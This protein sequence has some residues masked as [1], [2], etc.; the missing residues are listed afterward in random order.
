[1]SNK[2]KIYGDIESGSIFFVGST[3]D[4]KPLGGVV[5][6][7]EHPTIADRI[8][9]KRNDR[10]KRDRISFRVL[11]RKLN[12]NRICNKQGEELVEQLGYDRAQVIEYINGQANLQDGASAGGDGN[13]T[14]LIG[15][16]VCFKLDDTSTSVMIDTGHEFGVNTIKAIE[17]S[18]N[19][20]I[21]SELG[22]LVHFTNLEVGRVCGDDGNVV[23]GGLNDVI[24]Y[25]NELFTVGAFTQVVITDPDAT[26]VADVGGVDA[27][28]YVT[29]ANA[30]DPIG[31]DVYVN[32]GY[33]SLAGL[34]TTETISKQGEYFTFDIR[35]EGQ[36][37]FGLVHTQA[38]FDAGKW[39]GSS[40][41]GDPSKFATQN[42][43]HFGF[44]FSHWFHQ[45]PNGSWTNY[46]ANTSYITGPAWSGGWD[47]QQDWLDGE[48][49]KIK[50]GIDN[51][52]YIGIY[53]LNN[54]GITWKLHARTAYALPEGGE[55]RLGIKSANST[56]RVSSAPKVHLLPVTA[57]TMYFRYIESPDGVFQYPL[58][59]STEEAEY[60]DTEAGGSGTYHSHVYADDP[61]NTTWYMPDT[62]AVHNGTFAPV[63]DLTL[64]QPANYTEI[65][66]LSNSDLAPAAYADTS[67]TIDEG[68]TINIQ[69]Q[70][71]DTGYTTTFA[72]LPLGLIGF[73]GNVN[74]TAPQVVGDNVANPSDT[75]TI[76]VIR[77]N[78]YGSSTGTLTLVVNNLTAPV[79]TPITGVTDE[80]GTSL[81]DS[82]T[83]DDGSAVSID[84]VVNVGN[85]FT[86][87]KEWIDNYV[88]PK[89][90]SGTGAKAIYIGIPYD[91][92]DWSSV[93]INDFIVGYQFYSDDTARS[94]NNWRMRTISGG[95]II[96]NVGVGGQTNGLYDI[97]IVNDGTDLSYGG[98]V[99]SQGH[100]ISTY[101][102]NFSG[103]DS[104]WKYTGGITGVT[105]KDRK[106]VIATNGT[107][108]DL[109]LQYF[110]EYTEPTAASNLTSWSKALDFSGSNEYAVTTNAGQL[111]NPIRMSDLAVT[112]GSPTSSNYTSSV[113]NSRPWATAIVFRAD[114][115]NS[116]QHIWNQGEG[117][118]NTDD[119]IYLR[120]SSTNQLYF[121]WGRDGA[122]NECALGTIQTNKWYGVYIA[123]NGAR[124]S[125]ANATAA[126]LASA[127][128]IK[129]TNGE[130]WLGC[131]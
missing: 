17:N 44:Q 14:D 91:T 66:S 23:A 38:S 63:S 112:V 18:G 42:S 93:G 73:A 45:T 130:Y 89:I 29:G 5:F 16:D 82:D 122:L 125:G 54:D 96:N 81:V 105:S 4:P 48:N 131:T 88:L 111:N 67:F 35:N 20:D 60:Y 39:S 104:T 8:V 100:N 68:Q 32:N 103:V 24:N 72:N 36:I 87:D 120:L 77:T 114:G 7:E 12:I 117:A 78:S 58:F 13:G 113:T 57:P 102:F 6:A 126:N 116:N 119:N 33:N 27:G 47:A 108:M 55:Y 127:F 15:Q 95:S 52:G 79:V 74:G 11:F 90:T 53:S 84:N 97:A 64:G 43:A 98:L 106:V 86:L 2:L 46:G 75:Y 80:G 19:I 26:T 41:Y 28:G 40:Y 70:P 50:V 22:D 34:L 30:E 10:F 49:V 21:V 61:T 25:L 85:R 107:D 9:V 3:V 56:P 76:D 37:G 69:T 65:T 128:D 110:G 31:D 99:A 101:I 62:N 83:L 92:A 59:A 94:Q 124:F 118:G 115:N 123:H 121:G 51:N 129:I 1:M 109:D 71:Q